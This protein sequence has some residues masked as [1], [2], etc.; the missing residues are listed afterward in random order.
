MDLV[1]HH[2]GGRR[3]RRIPTSGR[4]A[5]R[6]GSPS[7]ASR[8]CRTLE[9][10]TVTVLNGTASSIPPRT[11]PTCSRRAATRSSRPARTRPRTRRASPTRTRSRTGIRR[12][13]GRRR[14]PRRLAELFAPATAKPLP[15]NLTQAAG[16]SMTLII[17]GHTFHTRLRPRRRR[18]AEEGAAA[19]MTYSLD[20]TLPLVRSADAEPAVWSRTLPSIQEH[21]PSRS[22]V[23]CVDHLDKKHRPRLTLPDRRAEL[24]D[25]G[26]GARVPRRPRSGT[27]PDPSSSGGI[28][29]SPTAGICTWVVLAKDGAGSTGREHA[30]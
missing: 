21:V 8:A 12:G 1:E 26:A 27:F 17:V 22:D 24:W 5:T 7:A 16:H 20:V 3:N 6:R 11:L 29:S 23:L 15:A 28:R 9:E 25:R 18:G 14:R 2:R 4:P 30:L 19:R 10:T 13:S